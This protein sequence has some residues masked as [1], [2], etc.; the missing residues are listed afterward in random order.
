VRGVGPLTSSFFEVALRALLCHK[1]LEEALLRLMLDQACA[2]FG[3]HTE[4][5][6]WVGQFQAQQLFDVQAG[7]YSI[8]CLT[9]GK[10]FHLL[11]KA[12]QSQSPGS[13]CWFPSCWEQISKLAIL[14]NCP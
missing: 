13:F 5:E 8:C 6:A 12:N 14:K 3:E 4:I 7:S 9:I 2:E 10:I 11:H 1:K